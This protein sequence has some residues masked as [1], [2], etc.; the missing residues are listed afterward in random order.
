MSVSGVSNTNF[1]QTNGAKTSFQQIQDDFQQLG[2]AL[3][4]ILKM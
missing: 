3:L 2:Q 1:Y 4:L